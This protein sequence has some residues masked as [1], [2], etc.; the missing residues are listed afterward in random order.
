MPAPDGVQCA[1]LV[2]FTG[3]SQKLDVLRLAVFVNPNPHMKESNAIPI[4]R[5]KNK[6][7]A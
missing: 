1:F 2:I 3:R 6:L 5:R 4:L 7:A